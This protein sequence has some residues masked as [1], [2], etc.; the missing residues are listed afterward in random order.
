MYTEIAMNKWFA[1]FFT[2]FLGGTAATVQQIQ[3]LIAAYPD[4]T[5]VIVTIYGVTMNLVASPLRPRTKE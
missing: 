4:A 5:I 3:D 1:V 2:C